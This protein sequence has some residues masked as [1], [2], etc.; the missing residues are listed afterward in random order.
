MYIHKLLKHFPDFADA[1]YGLANS[2]TARGAV[3]GVVHGRHD[4]LRKYFE[5]CDDEAKKWYKI[6]GLTYS[7][8][9]IDGILNTVTFII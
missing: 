1:W 2:W 7:T 9:Q 8:I 4:C 3:G 6:A 5:L